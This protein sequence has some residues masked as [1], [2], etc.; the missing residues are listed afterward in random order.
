M[1]IVPNNKKFVHTPRRQL[2]V[3]SLCVFK[4][5]YV[6]KYEPKSKRK[7]D[8][9]HRY[10]NDANERVKVTPDTNKRVGP[11]SPTELSGFVLAGLFGMCSQ[12]VEFVVNGYQFANDILP[13]LIVIVGSAIAILYGYGVDM[14]TVVQQR[15]ANYIA[16]A[17]ILGTI[18]CILGTIVCLFGPFL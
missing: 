11:K 2:R 6:S 13:T 16:Y 18:V 9:I 7:R 5:N 1:N 15:Y 14:D 4:Q 12:M 8:R 3:G 10:L 17:C